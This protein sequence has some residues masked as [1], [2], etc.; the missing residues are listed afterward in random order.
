[1]SLNSLEERLRRIEEM[2]AMVLDRLER[3]ERLAGMAG[4]EARLS[5]EIALAFAAPAQE[6][7]AAARRVA[8]ALSRAGGVM[9]DDGITRAI[10]EALAVNGPMTLRG[11]ERE[12]RKLRG[13]A[14]RT[15]IRERLRRLEEL[16]V[17]EID[18]RGRR[19]VIR[20]AGDKDAGEAGGSNG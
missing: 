7:V 11:L 18:R 3:L 9:V 16:G 20:L 2:L 15:V 19:M 5:V 4:E 10:V 6:A 1:M 13:T 12:V 8:E 14:S 17:V